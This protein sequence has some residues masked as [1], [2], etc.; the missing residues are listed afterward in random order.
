MV[1]VV[2]LLILLVFLLSCDNEWLRGIKSKIWTP[3]I[4][5]KVD[6]AVKDAAG[7][8]AVA[9]AGVA[10]VA[11]G[12]EGF[13]IESE[14][15]LTSDNTAEVRG[16]NF[17]NTRE[18]STSWEPSTADFENLGADK[19]YKAYAEDLKSNVDQAI[20][21]SHAEYTEDSAFLASTGASHASARDDFMPAVPFHGLPRKAHY[22]NVGAERTARTAQS[23]TPEQVYDLMEHNSTGYVL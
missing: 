19:L 8:A 17:I 10:Q 9:T 6:G 3:A 5:A 16:E 13:N 2:I 12:F 18:T 1:I 14:L 11:T 22:S 20:V 7:V 23:E 15:V 21:E 4:E